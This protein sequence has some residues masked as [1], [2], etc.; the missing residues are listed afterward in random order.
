M[1]TITIQTNDDY[2]RKLYQKLKSDK[3]LN[4]IELKDNIKEKAVNEIELILPG[5]PISDEML[6]ATL[7]FASKGKSLSLKTARKKTF[8]KIAAWRKN[9]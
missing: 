4:K 2:G 9:K 7:T 1:T 5:T 6:L 3:N 8:S